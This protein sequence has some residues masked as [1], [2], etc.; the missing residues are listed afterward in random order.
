[1]RVIT[2]GGPTTAP[3]PG[4]AATVAETAPV[5]TP[6]GNEEHTLESVL[7]AIRGS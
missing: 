2:A 7:A 1:M 6:A 3:A 5:E 4:A